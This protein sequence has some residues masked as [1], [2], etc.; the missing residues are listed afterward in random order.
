MQTFYNIDGGYPQ[1]TQD[2]LAPILVCIAPDEAERIELASAW[3]LD[4]FDIDSALDPDEVSRFEWTKGHFS[5]IWKRPK[6]ASMDRGLRLD[7]SSCGLFYAHGKLLILLAEAPCPLAAKQFQHCASVKEVI[8]AMLLHIVLHYVGHLKVIKQISNALEE[9]ITSTTENRYLVQMFHLSENMIY[10]VDAIESN[11]A[12]LFKLRAAAGRMNLSEDEISSL[13]ELILENQQCAR[14][15]HI[16]SAVLS[17]LMDAR[18]S[19]INNNMTVLLKKLTII[20]LVFLPL[21]LIAGIGGM[22]E[23][24]SWTHNL[25][26]RLS[27]GLFCLGMIALGWLTWWFMTRTFDR[28]EQ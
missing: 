23:F 21:N 8:L 7:V 22:S 25:D 20:N 13:D 6:S 12:T 19:I 16:Y 27:Y 9:K 1:L 4:P 2:P 17:G 3:D 26:W 28:P 14:Q 11:G 10:Y 24:S 15:A 5:L 18:G